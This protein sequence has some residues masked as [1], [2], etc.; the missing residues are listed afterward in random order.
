MGSLKKSGAAGA[1]PKSVLIVEDQTLFLEFLV[2]FI[3][4]Q[5]DLKVV[6]TASDGESACQC[7]K[8]LRPDLVLLDILIPRKSGIQVAA[9]IKSK[10]PRTRILAMSS[11]TDPK[12]VYQVNQ[13]RL[14][15]FIDKNDA[16]VET[17]TTA[18]G[19]IREQR[20]YVSPTITETLKHLR[21]DP[22]AFQK[23]HTPREQEVLAYVG[24]S[25]SDADIAER[26]GLSK[27]SIQTHKRNICRKLDC[28]STR[29][30]IRFAVDHGFW[31]PSFRRMGLVDTYHRHD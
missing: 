2:D 25:L 8:A 11:E 13:L 17:L 4:S 10:F 16:S 15:G 31:K 26:L 5:T 20:Q 21:Q 30:L 22:L 24:G 28:S 18:L 7:V 14:A 23:I 19:A 27:T 6:G 1:P 29:E 12:T 3:H 9:W